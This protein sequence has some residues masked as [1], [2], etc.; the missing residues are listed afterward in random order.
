M[1]NHLLSYPQIGPVSPFRLIQKPGLGFVLEIRMVRNHHALGHLVALVR[2]R[3]L[4][5]VRRQVICARSRIVALLLLHHLHVLLV[6]LR[7]RLW[8]SRVLR[9]VRVWWSVRQVHRRRDRDVRRHD[10]GRAV[11]HGHVAHLNTLRRIELMG[12]SRGGLV[13]GLLDE[14]VVVGIGDRHGHWR[15]VLVVGVLG[16]RVFGGWSRH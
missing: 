8:V 3:W 1:R 11:V 7:T 12:W 2:G 14:I 5:I 15:L 13:V 4:R 9:R 16:S 6:L 10:R